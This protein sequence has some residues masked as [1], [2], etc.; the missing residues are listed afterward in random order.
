MDQAIGGRRK[1]VFGYTFDH[2]MLNYVALA[3][4]TVYTGE[5]TFIVP[6]PTHSLLNPTEHRRSRNESRHQRRLPLSRFVQYHPPTIPQYRI[7]IMTPPGSFATSTCIS[8]RHRVETATLRETI[9]KKQVPRCARCSAREA[10]RTGR[11]RK[12]DKVGGVYK[13]RLHKAGQCK[14]VA[15]ASDRLAGYHVF[16]R[17][18][19]ARI[20]Y[21]TREGYTA[22]GFVDCDW[23][24]FAYTTGQ[25]YSRYVCILSGVASVY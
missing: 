3:T 18:S 21:S 5:Q 22:S 12:S 8:C 13:V 17:A 25:G 9:I 7:H 11:K 23:D 20:S 4:T 14:R 16:S 1:G 15:E 6:H 2:N 19:T 24:E 10:A